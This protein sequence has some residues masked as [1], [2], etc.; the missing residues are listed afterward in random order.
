MKHH[1]T[2]HHKKK[3][4]RPLVYFLLF[5]LIPVLAITLFVMQEPQ[6]VRQ[7]AAEPIA[8]CGKPG[9][10]GNEKGVGK[11]CNSSV[12]CLGSGSPICSADIRPDDPHICS[13]PCSTDADCGSGAVCY[14]DVLGKGC[15]P[16]ACDAPVPTATTQPTAT[17]AP[18]ATTAPSATNRPTMTTAPSVTKAPTVAASITI[19]PSVTQTPTQTVTVSPTL[20]PSATTLSLSVL[21]HGIG[22]GGDSVN[23]SSA[24]SNKSPKRTDRLFTVT[25]F[26]GANQIVSNKTV[27][28]TY[29]TDT[30]AYEGI[31]NL[32]DTW[33]GSSYSLKIKT[34]SFLDN[35]QTNF[36][37]PAKK[38]TDVPEVILVV[39][40]VNGDNMLNTLDYNLI[41][42]CFSEFA[43]AASCSESQLVA[44]DLN[45]D[46]VVNRVDYN[47]FL[48]EI[49]AQN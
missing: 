24:L 6:D 11:Y 9:D 44:S 39:G 40:D 21:L 5:L 8:G 43:T 46:G 19:A 3:E 23:I 14:Q 27:P 37:I 20:S 48:R 41:T 29:N 32:G 18:T 10:P 15:K 22:S 31:V 49:S 47:L 16:V 35:V 42:G 38:K 33:L 30:G 7:R 17:K 1:P 34:E 12:D 45:D 36:A 2:H 4:R 25:V 28:L 13:K 26:T